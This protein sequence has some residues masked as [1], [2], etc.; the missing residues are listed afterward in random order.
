MIDPSDPV[1]ATASP[2]SGAGVDEPR[3]PTPAQ[4]YLDDLPPTQHPNF[5]AKRL[6]LAELGPVEVEVVVSAQGAARSCALRD[7][8]TSGAAFEWPAELETSRGARLTDLSVL[9]DHQEVYRGDARIQAVREVGG[10][11]IVGV[12]FLGAPMNMEDVRK[13]REIHEHHA[14][15]QLNILPSE[16]DW[17]SGDEG[18]HHFEALV[19]ELY[20]FLREARDRFAALERDLP[21]SVVHGEKVTPARRVL[22]GQLQTGFVPAYVAYTERI[23][24]AL[25]RAPPTQADS[26]K[27]FSRALLHDTL[28]QA[29]FMHRCLTKPQG[30]PGDYVVMQYLYERHF[31]GPSLL[32]KAIHLGTVNTRGARAV[33]ERKNL[34]LCAMRDLVRE[35]ARR[36]QR[37]RVVSIAAGPAQ[38]TL[39]L[40]L[41]EPELAPSLDI[42]LFDQDVDALEYV[43]TRLGAAMQRLGGEGPRTQLRHDTI[44][45]LL[46]DPD[47]FTSFG[48]VDLVFASGL[49]D[50]LHFHT[51]VRLIGNLYRILA[52]GG[53]LYVGN[54]VPENPCRW[55]L[56]HHLDWV[57]EYRTREELLAMGDA[58]LP[59]V[60]ARIV[61]EATGVNPFLVIP[62]T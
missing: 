52:P 42:L 13:L 1:P 47:I 7:I 46:N 48:D 36:G 39:E 56:E 19:A 2:R 43:N 28:L 5:R 6:R 23:D 59:G 11:T 21:W 16:Q 35:R 24:A 27:A 55:F 61:D 17:H 57:L 53:L 58:A 32:A 30:Y 18:V 44:R 62:R 20:L 51:G 3:G 45:A 12:S 33:R 41:Q 26:M 29:P 38:E 14:V 49:F 50:Y 60:E 4:V 15:Q 9:C 10:Q 8:S 25:R 40:I 37:A 31:E 34:L 54:M 22:M